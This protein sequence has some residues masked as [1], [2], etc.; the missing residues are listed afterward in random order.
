MGHQ[1]QIMKFREIYCNNCKKILGRYN[2]KF[3]D[4]DKIKEILKSCHS[5]HVRTGHRV[6]LRD[7]LKQEI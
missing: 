4:D 6:I 3:Y 2:T 7:F 5:A 1:G